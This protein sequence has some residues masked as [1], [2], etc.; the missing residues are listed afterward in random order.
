MRYLNNSLVQIEDGQEMRYIVA[1]CDS[2]EIKP[3]AGVVD[4]SQILETDT[5]DIYI[6]N[7]L[8]GAWVWMFSLK[9]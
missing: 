6:F 8:S 9:E 3:T 7:E 1:N 4:G 5:G 2:S